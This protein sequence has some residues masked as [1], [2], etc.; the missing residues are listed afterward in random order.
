LKEVPIMSSSPRYRVE[1]VWPPFKGKAHKVVD[2]ATVLYLA[3]D[4]RP[5]YE[6]VG[7]YAT[8]AGAARKAKEMNAR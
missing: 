5:V 6:G 7:L 8:P 3:D 2:T 1:K 4:G